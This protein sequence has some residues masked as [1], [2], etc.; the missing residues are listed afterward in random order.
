MVDEEMARSLS[1]VSFLIGNTEMVK[2]MQELPAMEPFTEILLDMLNG[3]ARLLITDHEA[4]QYPDVITFAFWIRKASTV[5][6]KERFYKEDGNLHLGRGVVFHIAP[7]NV[8]AVMKSALK[9]PS[10]VQA[11]VYGPLYPL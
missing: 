3:V 8:P 6:L 5:R 2:R 9:T 4:K 7:S 1:G 10:S 11:V